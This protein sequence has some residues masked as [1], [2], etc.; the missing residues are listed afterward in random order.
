MESSRLDKIKE[1]L[2][3]EP[4]DSFLRYAFAIELEKEG[5]MEESIYQIEHLLQTTPLYSGA[6][7][8][9]G[10]LLELT[11]QKKKA[12]DVYNKGIA[13]AQQLGQAKALRELREA[14]QNLEDE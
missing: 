11:G 9:L 14:L 1:M 8:K 12:A 7:Y 5:K 13:V 6:Y 10:Q 4:G 2:E 3:S